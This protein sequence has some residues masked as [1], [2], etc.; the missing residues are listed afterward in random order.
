MLSTAIAVI[1]LVLDTLQMI[2]AET[3]EMRKRM[4]LFFTLPLGW[5]R[6]RHLVTYYLEDLDELSCSDI[7]SL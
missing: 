2:S 5:R 6:Q 3:V 7:A 1:T 4:K